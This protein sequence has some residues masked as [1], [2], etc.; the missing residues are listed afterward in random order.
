MDVDVYKMIYLTE[1]NGDDIEASGLVCIPSEAGSYPVLSFQNGTNTK[2]SDAPTEK[3]SDV[4][5]TLVEAIASMGF[6]VVIPDY[7]GFGSSAQIPHPYL[8]AEPT[9][10]AIVDM[11]RAVK[12]GAGT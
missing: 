1:I 8:I 6:I 3:V 2:H 11:F 9:V 7:P 5:Y 4:S 12:E 10:Q